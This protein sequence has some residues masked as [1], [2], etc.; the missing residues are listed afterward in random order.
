MS[1][2]E[3]A[4]AVQE[5]FSE[6][7]E[8]AKTFHQEGGLGCL[9][10]CGFCCS[11]PKVPAS[12]LEFLP[13]AFDL[14]SKGIADEIAKQLAMEEEP[15]SCVVYRKLS[16]DGKKGFCGNYSQRGLICRLFA[17][18]ARRNQKTGRK[19]LITCKPL[20][21]EKAEAYR[22]VSEKINDTMEIPMASQWYTRLSDIDDHLNQLYP[23][24][25]AIL[26]ALELVL[27]YR[28]YTQGEEGTAQ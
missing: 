18:S 6:L 26:M 22:V 1:L 3:K 5:L 8:E 13:L 2:V 25:Q 28:F 20:K 24:N 16:D 17:A 23:I 11:N 9:S 14:E 27:T 4:R 10:G 12:P 19:E 7:E 15:G 21:E